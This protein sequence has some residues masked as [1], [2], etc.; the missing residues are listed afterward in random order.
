MSD[1]AT[2][3]DRVLIPR[4]VSE[5]T[6]DR[7]DVK[8]GP[9]ASVDM[10]RDVRLGTSSPACWLR[11]GART[12]GYW[13]RGGL[14][15]RAA[16]R[17]ACVSA[18]ELPSELGRSLLASLRTTGLDSSCESS[19]W[20]M[21]WGAEEGKPRLSGE[22]ILAAAEV[23]MYGSKG[24]LE[25]RGFLAPALAANV[26]VLPMVSDRLRFLD[27][28]EDDREILEKAAAPGRLANGDDVPNLMT[29]GLDD[30]SAG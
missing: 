11:G 5:G 17:L 25:A 24:G 15:L 16:W 13:I 21:L 22:T 18:R 9:A 28:L 19:T 26:C 30:T 2:L 20:R 4:E 10:D 27:E 23:G 29:F 8:L 6:A 3:A 14:E 1:E 12:I 7:R